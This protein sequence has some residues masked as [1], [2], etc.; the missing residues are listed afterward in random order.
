MNQGFYLS[1]RMGSPFN[2]RPVPQAVIDALTEVSVSSSVGSQGG[3]QMKF[4]LGKNSPLHQNLLS[5]GYFDPRTR[6]IIAVTV[7]G[8]PS[9]LMDGIITDQQLGSRT[10]IGVFESRTGRSTFISFSRDFSA[11]SRKP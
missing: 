8:S 5:S 4:T 1:L 3:F 7:N 2:P 11:V 6:V 9:V 10:M